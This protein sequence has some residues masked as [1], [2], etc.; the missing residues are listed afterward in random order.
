MQ[1]TWCK[2]STMYRMQETFPSQT[3]E[4]LWVWMELGGS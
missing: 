4:V 1:F 3:D 2:P